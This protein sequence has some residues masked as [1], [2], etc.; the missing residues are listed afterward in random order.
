MKVLLSRAW[1]LG[2]VAS[3]LEA[4][5]GVDASHPD[6]LP[7]E[8]GIHDNQYYLSS[9]AKAILELRLHRL[10]GLEHEKIVDE[11]KQILVEIGE[12]LHI[13]NSSERLKCFVK[14]WNV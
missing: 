3:M 9:A 1:S 8:C 13:L 4:T 12:L 6:D 14:N 2:N 10:T 11:Y 7:A 5:A